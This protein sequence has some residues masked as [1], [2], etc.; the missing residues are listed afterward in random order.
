MLENLCMHLYEKEFLLTPLFNKKGL[1]SL[2]SFFSFFD[3]LQ[4]SYTRFMYLLLCDPFWCLTF[5]RSPKT[6]GITQPLKL[7]WPVNHR[8]CRLGLTRC[9]YVQVHRR[10]LYLPKVLAFLAHQLQRGATSK[11]CCNFFYSIFSVLMNIWYHS[12]QLFFFFFD[13]LP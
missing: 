2:L 6:C 7:I 10:P 1:K 12:K 9:S 4:Q 13:E 5:C 11:E 8:A 3:F